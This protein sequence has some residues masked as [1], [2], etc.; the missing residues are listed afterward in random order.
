MKEVSQLEPQIS[1]LIS[2]LI[3]HIHTISEDE[4]NE[5]GILVKGVIAYFI[6]DM[7]DHEKYFE[8]YEAAKN[9]TKPDN[10]SVKPIKNGV[11]GSVRSF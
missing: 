7:K 2:G 3:E 6:N 11:S 1:E 4:K 10:I 8:V 9:K 5:L